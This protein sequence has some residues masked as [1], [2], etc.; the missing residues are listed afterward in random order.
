MK[1]ASKSRQVEPVVEHRPQHAVAV[2]EVV[3]VVVFAAQVD[4]GQRDLAG[5]LHVQLALAGRAAFD[6]RAAPAEPE[7]AAC[8]CSAS[9]SATARPPAAALRGSATRLETTTRRLMMRSSYLRIP[10]RRQAHRCVDDADHRI[11]LRKVAPHLAGDRVRVFGQQAE[12]G[13]ARASMV[14]KISRAS[15]LRPMRA[16]ASMRQKVQMLKAVSGL[17]KSSGAS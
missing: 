16:S 1:P 14:S 8:C 12:R 17:P 13:C 4:G 7:A 3:A 15:S 6:D 9:P 5:L 10:G 11:G 2:A